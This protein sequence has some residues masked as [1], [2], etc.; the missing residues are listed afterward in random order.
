MCLCIQKSVEN[1]E[2]NDE[3][4]E[5]P[6]PWIGHGY[7]WKHG[8]GDKWTDLSS[9]YDCLEDGFEQIRGCRVVIADYELLKHDFPSLSHSSNDEINAWLLE[10]CI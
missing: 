7:Y 10:N 3:K 1:D 4:K 9:D 5:K 6:L 2:E 8:K